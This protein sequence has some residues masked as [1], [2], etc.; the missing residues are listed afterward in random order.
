MGKNDLNKAV[1]CAEKRGL[2]KVDR[3]ILMCVDRKEAGC[4]GSKEMQAAWKHLK[5]KLKESGLNDKHGVLRLKMQCCGLCKGG[6]IAVVV[7]DMIW[8]GHC[9]PG[10]H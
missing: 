10:R 5:R 8:Y 2:G 7:P 4:A 6:P 9:S 1:V 3:M